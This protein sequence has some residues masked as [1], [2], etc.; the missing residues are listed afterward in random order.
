MRAYAPH[1][2][3]TPLDLSF[4]DLIAD[5]AELERHTLLQLRSPRWPN[6]V[7]FVIRKA[8]QAS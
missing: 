7:A 4:D 8:R 2:A 6:N 5:L 3:H 1:G